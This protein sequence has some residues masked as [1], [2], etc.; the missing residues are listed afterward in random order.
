[1]Y[2]RVYSTFSLLVSGGQGV[3]I[4]YPPL[5]GFVPICVHRREYITQIERLDSYHLVL[6]VSK[7]DYE[8]WLSI[9]IKSS[10][11]N[12]FAFYKTGLVGVQFLNVYLGE[13]SEIETKTIIKT[14][15]IIFF[16][17]NR[18]CFYYRNY[19]FYF[20]V[21]YSLSNCTYLQLFSSS[22]SSKTRR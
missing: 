6:W 9:E 4:V 10:V 12:L 14:D 2:V 11:I 22:S 13:M 18:I 3:E 21:A 20:F 16:N 15:V 7:R 8:N 1:M 19:M 17:N 5:L